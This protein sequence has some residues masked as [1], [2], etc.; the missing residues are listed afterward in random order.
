MSKINLEDRQTFTRGEFPLIMPSKVSALC[1]FSYLQSGT[2]IVI[3]EG[4]MFSLDWTERWD[5]ELLRMHSI[6]ASWL[7]CCS[8]YRANLFTLIYIYFKTWVRSKT[9]KT[10]FYTFVLVLDWKIILQLRDKMMIIKQ[11]CC[12]ISTQNKYKRIRHETE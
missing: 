9:D 8:T 7:K 10:Y 5:L 2:K 3:Y 4:K 6:L 11:Q 12:K 1:F